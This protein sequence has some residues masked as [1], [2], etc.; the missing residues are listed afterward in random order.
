MIKIPLNVKYI[1]K[2][3]INGPLCENYSLEERKNFYLENM[4]AILNNID[5]FKTLFTEQEA[6]KLY[7]ENNFLMLY[8]FFSE[9]E[10]IKNLE[11]ILQRSTRT[12]L[13]CACKFENIEKV[14]ELASKHSEKR[15]LD[16]AVNLYRR[17]GEIFDY[18]KFVNFIKKHKDCFFDSN[19]KYC[20]EF[21]NALSKEEV[22]NFFKEHSDTML[23]NAREF[24]S[25]K[26]VISRID[27]NKLEIFFGFMNWFKNVDCHCDFFEMVPDS[28]RSKLF[29]YMLDKNMFE[30]NINDNGV[31]QTLNAKD[32]EIALDKY[33]NNPKN[34]GENTVR[35]IQLLIH[36]ENSKE[37][38]IR[39]FDKYAF[40]RE[41]EFFKNVLIGLR[42]DDNKDFL[43][44][45]N[46]CL[47]QNDEKSLM[48]DRDYIIEALEQLEVWPEVF[49]GEKYNNILNCYI[50]K[51]GIT[52]VNNFKKMLEK[53]DYKVLGYISKYK[54]IVDAINMDE[55]SFDKYLALFDKENTKL[56]EK[57]INAIRNAVLQRSFRII[58]SDTYNVFSKFEKLIQKEDR[59]GI[60]KLLGKVIFGRISVLEKELDKINETYDSFLNSLLSRNRSALNALHNLTNNYIAK[61][62]DLY[63]D[64]RLKWF[65]TSLITDEIYEKNSIKKY[66]LNCNSEWNIL[67]NIE[68]NFT[69]SNGKEKELFDNKEL[70]WK[71]I[72]YR[73]L[74]QSN[75]DSLTKEDDK[76]KVYLKTLDNILDS[77]YERGFF[78]KYY[79]VKSDMKENGVKVLKHFKEAEDT[80]ILDIM[81]YMNI[82]GVK[83]NL[84]S[85]DE[86]YNTFLNEYI[87]KYKIIGWKDIFDDVFLFA[88]IEFNDLTLSSAFSCFNKIYPASKDKGLTSFIDYSN[89]FGSSSRKY[90]VLLGKED[91]E[92]YSTNPGPNQSSESKATRLNALPSLL[93]KIYDKTN[94]TVPPL[95]K[96]FDLDG[97]KLNVNIGNFTNPM[98]ITYGER[99][100]ACLR[101]GGAYND[102]FNFCLTDKN[103]FHI[104]FTNPDTGEFVSRVSGIRNGNT[105][106]LNEL[107]TSVVADYDDEDLYEV[108]KQVAEELVKETK[109][110]GAP[111][112]NVIVSTQY[113]LMSH[114]KES[115][116]L[117]LSNM[118]EALY[119]LNF[120]LEDN[121]GLVLAST[122][123]DKLQFKFGEKHSKNYPVLSDNVIS[124]SKEN[125]EASEIQEKL[126]RIHMIDMIL[127]GAKMED[128]DL[129][130]ILSKISSFDVVKGICG[131][132]FYVYQDTKGDYHKYVMKNIPNHEQVVKEVNERL[133]K[134]KKSRKGII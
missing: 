132:N 79:P 127:G 11:I 4:W 56:D 46:R 10:R 72:E 25:S 52:N 76:Y 49:K 73:K 38:K 121:K 60:E 130:S 37:D 15:L 100:E 81:S 124:F 115:Q 113:A 50:K 13:L 69:P 8:P 94:C 54:S 128:I 34:D 16:I 98:N 123:K 58:E 78:D 114:D 108:L 92:L 40:S 93:K 22:E 44:L 118:K 97:R 30:G 122:Y 134:M 28:I 90:R 21:L 17:N 120:D 12:K 1:L 125:N 66:Y 75:S 109:N 82:D 106:F 43:L 32:Y 61:A 57:S 18:D 88:D 26:D 2:N 67:Q 55:K 6:D 83:K 71:V 24:A 96:D 85:N 110:S 133:N 70:L 105:I 131:D 48:I 89:C 9:K 117:G 112:E 45:M 107:R 86:L 39:I 111:I 126:A 35:L 19:G 129:D 31:F 42:L 27:E 104:R 63:V 84:L 103:G 47:Q 65:N 87:K 102:L 62:R 29:D 64:Q 99:T 91:Y 53:F 59:E 3:G 23:F 95:N 36:K 68:D 41:E 101:Y 20:V 33:L 7:N 51:Y 80:H 119:N 116:K 74:L 14:L 77:M 5:A